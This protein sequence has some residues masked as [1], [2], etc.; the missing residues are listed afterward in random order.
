MTRRKILEYW[1]EVKRIVCGE[2]K[3]TTCCCEAPGST[4]KGCAIV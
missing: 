4:P 3:Q 2:V 1:T